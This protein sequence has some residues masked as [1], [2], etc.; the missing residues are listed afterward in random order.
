MAA[1]API[2]VLR[3][4]AVIGQDHPGPGHVE[5]PS[6]RYSYIDQINYQLGILHGMQTRKG[7]VPWRSCMHVPPTSTGT[8]TTTPA[9]DGPVQAMP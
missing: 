8:S 3:T 7:K 5:E 1:Q 9:S 2:A 6:C 4:G